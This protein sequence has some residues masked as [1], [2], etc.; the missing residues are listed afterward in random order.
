MDFVSL[1]PISGNKFKYDKAQPAG[2][3]LMIIHRNVQVSVDGK[4]VIVSASDSY[5]ANAIYIATLD[6]NPRAMNIQKGLV[7][8]FSAVDGSKYEVS[9]R[10]TFIPEMCA[11]HY[12]KHKTIFIVYASQYVTNLDSQFLFL[13]DED[14]ANGRLIVVDIGEEDNANRIAKRLDG[15][16]PTSELLAEDSNKVLSWVRFVDR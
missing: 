11:F 12:A 6:E 3:K 15:N 8:I 2:T 9:F 1:M 10:A 13:T 16:Y 5:R 4:Y 7:P 14:A